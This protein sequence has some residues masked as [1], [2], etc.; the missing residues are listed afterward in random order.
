VTLGL[1]SCLIK[2]HMLTCT[3]MAIHGLGMNTTYRHL[4][5][6]GQCGTY[7]QRNRGGQSDVFL[8]IMYDRCNERL[9]NLLRLG[10]SA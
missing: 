4:M 3:S 9:D 5:P 8:P 7:L 2:R 6:F 10:E 1:G